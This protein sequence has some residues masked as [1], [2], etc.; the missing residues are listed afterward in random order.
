MPG[1]DLSPENPSEAKH[2]RRLT[3]SMPRELSH[4]GRIGSVAETE[5]GSVERFDPKKYCHTMWSV[6]SEAT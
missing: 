2:K 1:R 5:K 4:A 6:V 3:A